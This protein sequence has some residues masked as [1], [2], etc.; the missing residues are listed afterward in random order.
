MKIFATN[1]LEPMSEDIANENE[2]TWNP[3]NGGKG[4]G[5]DRPTKTTMATGVG[6]FKET[7][8]DYDM[9]VESPSGSML[10]A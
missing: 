10:V 6:K 4:T 1:Y 3:V 9:P 8:S 7:C 2:W 5:P